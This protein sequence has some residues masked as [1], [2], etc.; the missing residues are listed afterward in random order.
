VVLHGVDAGD[1]EVGDLP[2]AA[3]KVLVDTRVAIVAVDGVVVRGGL[4]V[5]QRGDDGDGAFDFDVDVGG[6]VA[7]EN[8]L[9]GAHAVDL[10][11]LGEDVAVPHDAEV[12]GREE[13]FHSGGIVAYLRGAPLAF[14]GEDLVAGFVLAVWREGVQRERGRQDERGGKKTFCGLR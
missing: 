3:G 11:R 5:G 2:R 4:H 6:F 9:S 14:E 10:L 1:F 8:E 12:I 13:L 7:G